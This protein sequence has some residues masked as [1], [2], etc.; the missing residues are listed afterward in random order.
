MDTILCPSCSTVNN[1]EETSCKNCGESLATAKFERSVEELRKATEK[2]KDLT[3]PRKS[4]YS[5]NGCGTMLL[6]YHALPDG[7]YEAT[8]WVTLFA[9]P[10]IPLSAYVIQ[11]ESQERSYGRETSK[12]SILDQ[13]PLSI[14]RILRTYGL[15]ALGLAPVIIGWYYSPWLNRTLGGPKAFF[16]MLLAIA[17]GV[18]IIFFRIK[19][20]SKAYKASSSQ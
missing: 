14:T 18:Y 20:D 9:L 2:L 12:F 19:N 4:F 17:W 5:F 13:K 7:T 15:V 6:D 10:L 1:L 11:P 16:A 8:R 3:V